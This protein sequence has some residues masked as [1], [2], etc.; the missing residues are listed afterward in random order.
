LD[1]SSI[2]YII[3]FIV[4]CAVLLG[5]QGAYWFFAEVQRYRGAINRR[6]VLTKQNASA[7][8]VLEILRRE[9]GLI[10]LDNKYFAKLNHLIMQTGL[11]LDGKWLIAIACSSGLL[12]FALFGVGFGYG[13]ISF[14]LAA[15][16]GALSLALFLALM[17][18]KRI[19]KFSGQL[20]DAIDVIFRGVKAG[21]PFTIALG[22]VAKEMVDPIG[23]EF[24]MTS[25]EINFGSDMGAALDNLFYRVGHEDLLYLTMALKIQNETGG[26]LAEILSRLARLLRQRAMLRLK[27]RAI[28]SEGRLSAVVL[29]LMPFVLFGIISLVRPDYYFGVSDNPI[30]MPAVIVALTLLVVGNVIIYR[31][32]NF[33][34]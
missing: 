8:E 34:V 31:M 15:L 20:P 5:V 16:S 23:T 12:F 10:G 24:G 29:T 22:L 26:T 21:Y 32:V 2:I 9:R 18:S 25:D 7:Q 17:R 33:K 27:V 14:I 6:L 30:I 13:T 19:A 3:V 28:S 1:Q 11:R 4:F